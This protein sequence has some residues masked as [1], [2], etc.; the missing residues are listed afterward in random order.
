MFALSVLRSPTFQA[1]PSPDIALG[2][3]KAA[4]NRL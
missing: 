3:K 1:N 4:E 2:M